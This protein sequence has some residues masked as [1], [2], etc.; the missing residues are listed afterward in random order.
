MYKFI[1]YLF[2]MLFDIVIA[3]IMFVGRHS[4]AKKS[5]G[6][7]EIGAFAAIYGFVYILSSYLVGTTISLEKAKKLLLTAIT[8]MAILLCLLA[9]VDNY[10]LFLTIF[11]GVPFAAS[12]FF[13]S[14]QSY[15]LQ[16]N[17]N[18]VKNLRRSAGFYTFSW[19]LG[20][21]L[22]PIVSYFACEYF[23]WSVSFYLAAIIVSIVGIIAL[24]LKPD[25]SHNIDTH[26][27]DASAPVFRDKALPLSGW[28][29]ILIATS[30]FQLIMIYWPLQ[31]VKLHYSTMV[32]AGFESSATLTQALAALVI[33][34]FAR[35][36]HKSL[37][38]LFFGFIG[39]LGLFSLTLAN[40]P[41]LFFVGASLFGIYTAS[42]FIYMVYH[43]MLEK[44]KS[45]RR[46]SI[47]EIMVG[48]GIIIGPIIAAI[49]LKL[50]KNDFHTAFKSAL[51]IFSVAVVIQTGIAIREKKLSGQ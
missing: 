48:S 14:F 27:E 5:A 17:G 47:N 23:D 39:A 16:T 4:Y 43:S 25:K 21:A 30:S 24:F 29:G 8:L 6:V 40:D 28:I 35:W 32:K 50:A 44:E 49:C 26:H 19:S 1:I 46:T 3:L 13:N 38:L 15:M 11:S 7:I 18:S 41:Q 31:A 22:G 10:F 51:I 2:P 36:Y 33:C 20:F 37:M 45:I 34:L 12:L 42:S 9:N